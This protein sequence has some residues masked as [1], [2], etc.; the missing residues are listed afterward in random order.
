MK[1]S[2]TLTTPVRAVWSRLLPPPLVDLV[3][4]VEHG[5]FRGFDVPVSR[6]KDVSIVRVTLM[7]SWFRVTLVFVSFPV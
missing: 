2:L 4:L 5:V 3:Q 6:Y 7:C 1:S